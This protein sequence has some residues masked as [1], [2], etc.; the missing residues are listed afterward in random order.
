MIYRQEV[1]AA[2]GTR[3]SP[4]RCGCVPEHGNEGKMVRAVGLEPTRIATADFESAASTVSPRPH[5]AADPAPGL[6]S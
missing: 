1:V 2:I 4:T 3:A 5:F 6:G